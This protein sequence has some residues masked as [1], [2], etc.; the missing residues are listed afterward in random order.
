MERLLVDRLAENMKMREPLNFFP[1]PHNYFYF[2]CA[3]RNLP[4]SPSIH[5]VICQIRFDHWMHH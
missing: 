2:F 1:Q 3:G 5:L 4:E